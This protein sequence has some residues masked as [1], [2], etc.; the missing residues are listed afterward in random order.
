PVLALAGRLDL[1]TKSVCNQLH[2]VADTERRQVLLQYPVRQL[3]CVLGIDARRATAE[4]NGLR[5]QLLH[6]V[7]RCVMGNKFAKHTDFTHTA[8]DELTV[9]RAVIE[10]HR[11]INGVL[12]SGGIL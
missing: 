10:D 5:V 8:R 3:W 9:L 11:S 7:P 1:A 2:A 12:G 4:N 6:V